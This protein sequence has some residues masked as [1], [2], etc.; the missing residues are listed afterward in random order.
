MEKA[1]VEWGEV[2][3]GCVSSSLK[4]VEILV[5]REN[6]IVLQKENIHNKR[7]LPSNAVLFFGSEK[8]KMLGYQ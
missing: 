5:L 7:Q 1:E 4:L 6:W 8:L 2:W 3:T